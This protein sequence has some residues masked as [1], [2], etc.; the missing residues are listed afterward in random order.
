MFRAV[1]VACSLLASG[2]A[3][4]AVW[5]RVQLRDADGAE[6]VRLALNGATRRLARPRCRRLFSEFLD[7]R[8]RPLLVRLA[9]LDSSETSYL[10]L[11]VFADGSQT[12]QC[13]TRPT[14]AY[15]ERGSRVVFVCGERFQR[16]W[17][18]S[19]A[20]AESVL[21][22]EA[23]HTLGLGENPPSSTEITKRV[24]FYCSH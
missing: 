1:A 7:E 12:A 18:Q 11:L 5:P 13:R 2:A 16:V 21:I 20:K 15:T 14:F 9:E 17:H 24:Q 10:P 6:F 4:T 3:E 23:L 19:R 8:G 22:H